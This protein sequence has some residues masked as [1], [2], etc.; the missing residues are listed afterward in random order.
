MALYITFE[1]NSGTNW[2]I[3]EKNPVDYKKVNEIREIQADGHELEH[4]HGNF[5]NIPVANKRV[6]RYF[7]DI[8]KFIIGNL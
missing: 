6:V 2:H 5:S 8:A 1:D 3:G 7:G 4:I